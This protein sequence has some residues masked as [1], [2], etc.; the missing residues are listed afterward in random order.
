MGTWLKIDLGA[1][2]I[3]TGLAIQGNG[4]CR[5]AASG[6][7]AGTQRKLKCHGPCC[8]SVPMGVTAFKM[9]YSH[10]G[11]N[12]TPVQN[13]PGEDKVLKTNFDAKA[14]GHPDAFDT[15]GTTLPELSRCRPV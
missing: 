15:F 8:A 13:V 5:R 12:F 6:S 9:S 4:G 14:V 2:R 3:V 11:I 1:L 7:T 10:D